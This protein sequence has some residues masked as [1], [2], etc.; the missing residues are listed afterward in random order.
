MAPSCSL[1]LVA[2]RLAIRLQHI[3]A[4]YRGR[5]RLFHLTTHQETMKYP[6]T[7]TPETG[8][9][10]VTFRDIPEALTQGDIE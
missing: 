8:G 6:A 7:F 4:H 5:N 10:V 9:F 2:V 3:P 1:A